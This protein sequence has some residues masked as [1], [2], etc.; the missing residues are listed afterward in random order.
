MNKTAMKITMTKHHDTQEMLAEA[1]DMQISGLNARING[2]I[3]FRAGEIIKIV[4][5]YNLS[6][7]ET[8]AIF[9]EEEAS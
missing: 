8:T 2:K 3:D 4:K 7:E 1:L 6:P 5:R 9:F